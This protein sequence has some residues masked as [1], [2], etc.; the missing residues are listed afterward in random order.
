VQN[1]TQFFFLRNYF[2]NFFENFATKEFVRFTQVPS[3]K[4]GFSA[5]LFNI[6]RVLQ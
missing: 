5:R 4:S 2:L 6:L 3:V 1:C